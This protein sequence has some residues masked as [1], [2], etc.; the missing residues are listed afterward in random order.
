MKHK[1]NGK[2]VKELKTK[3]NLL[4]FL[5]VEKEF[6]RPMINIKLE[7]F[8][9]PQFPTLLITKATLVASSVDE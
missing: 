2:G 5:Q 7:L 6:K 4:D 1:V 3:K 9:S 8:P